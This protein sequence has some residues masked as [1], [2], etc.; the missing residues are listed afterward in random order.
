VDT[1]GDGVTSADDALAI[2][3]KLKAEGV[4]ATTD[5]SALNPPAVLVPPPRRQYDVGCGYTQVW[6][7]HAIA[8]T[9]TGGDRVTWAQL[10]DLVDA[11]ARAYPVETADAG[12]YV[13]ENKTLSS[14]VVV[15][16]T[17]GGDA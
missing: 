8:A 17:P 15:F 5:T 9:L 6:R 10:D 7:V 16:S 2:C 12:A 13:L 3:E 4:R 11:I 1:D 14:Y